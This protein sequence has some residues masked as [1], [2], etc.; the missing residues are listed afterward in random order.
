MS[1]KMKKIT[2]KS[3]GM[4]GRTVALFVGLAILSLAMTTHAAEVFDQPPPPCHPNPNAAQDMATLSARGDIV[5]LPQTLKDRLLRL[6]GRPHTYLP[7]QI[8]AEA[9]GASQLFQYYLLDTTGFE[10]NVFT[11]IF[12]GINDQ[13]QLTATGTNCGL[14]TVGAVRLALEPKPGLPT[15]PNDPRAFNDVFTDISGLFVINNE[16]GWYEGWM[17][18]DVV[19]PPVASPRSDGQAQFG[20]IT[21]AD[22]AALQKMG[23]GNNIPGNIFTM[24]G[25]AV[26][27][28]SPTDHFPDVQ[29]NVVPIQVSMGAYNC[30]QQSDCHA[31]WEFNYL[32]TNWVAPLYEL[33]FTGGFSDKIGQPADA[34]EKGQIGK[35]SSLVPGSGPK[36]IKNKADVYGDNPN[37]P[38]DPDKFDGDV[39]AQREFRFRNIPTGLANEILLD[40]YVRVASFH[41]SM[42]NL[43]D[44]LN[45][46]YAREVARVDQNGDG[47][48]SAVEGDIDTPSDGF[49]DNSRLFLPPTVFNRFA[50]TREINDGYLSPRFAPSQR[51]WVL[52]GVR[53]AVDPTVDASAGRDGDDR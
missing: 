35:L 48:I 19:V 47:V 17:I 15:D 26:H 30:L 24:D 22:A 4:N 32:G 25:N 2:K 52:S 29:T 42:K 6:A 27:F 53:V 41:S 18:H 34:F 45:E 49:A 43:E 11:S 38:R 9:D 51:A 8:F 3:K 40:V 28:P 1:G 14:P 21:A 50:V 5:N 36:G 39:D 13:V 10:P 46:A 37:L 20:M 16:S 31:Y 23:T 12:P 7:L 33:P 44:R